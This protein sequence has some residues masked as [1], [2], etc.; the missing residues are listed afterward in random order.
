MMNVDDDSLPW[1]AEWRAGRNFR[2]VA[3]LFTKRNLWAIA[4]I[5]EAI[6]K[7]SGTQRD[8]LLFAL[9]AI[10]L[11]CSRMYRYRESLKG[12]FQGGTYYIPQESQIINVFRAFCDKVEDLRR[13]SNTKSNGGDFIVSTQSACKLEAI[14]SNS[15]DY[16]FTG[17][18]YSH[19]VQYGEL[20]FIWEAWL[21]LDTH[22]HDEEIIVNDVRGKSHADWAFCMKQAMA[23]CYRV[24]KPGRWL[25]LCFHDEEGTWE[26]VQDFMA[27]VG[28]IVDK[29]DSA[30]FIDTGQKSYNQL[31]ADKA[32]NRSGR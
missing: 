13:A 7:V 6:L 20:N 30:L 16:V 1:G 4:A 21:G 31:T 8:L 24:L 11:N 12:G 22:W 10:T 29:T 25:T 19:T 15:I 18:P 23:E 2:T 26:L 9:N 28:F 14:A 32:R 3:E 17:P 5:R 27:E